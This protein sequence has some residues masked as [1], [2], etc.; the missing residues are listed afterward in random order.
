VLIYREARLCPHCAKPLTPIRYGVS[1]SPFAAQILDTV[2]QAG[3]AGI[4]A[5][6]LLK[7]A[8]GDSSGASIGTLRSYIS[9]LN[10]VL[11]ASGVA[12]CSQRRIYRIG[13]RESA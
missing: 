12:I 7:S 6:E 9:A 10:C 13:L 4:G 1:V 8:Y 2:E 5:A 11:R 3:A